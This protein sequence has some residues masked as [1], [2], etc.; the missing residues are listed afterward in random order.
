MDAT[1]DTR[2]KHQAL[3]NNGLYLGLAVMI[4]FF[5]GSGW[6]SYLNTRTLQENT[7][8]LTRSQD[9]LL[10][11]SE[12]LSLLKDAETGQRGY[13]I[14]GDSEY[15]EPYN[16]AVARIKEK[17]ADIEHLVE[18]NL[19]QKTMLPSLRERIDLKLQEL[20]ETIELRRAHGFEQAKEVIVT[21]RGKRTM[22][23]I[24]AREDEMQL[25]ERQLRQERVI[26]MEN[27]YRITFGSGIL[28]GLLGIVLSIAVTYLLRRAMLVRGRHEWLQTAQIRLAQVIAGDQKMV[29]LS[30]KILNFLTDSLSAQAGALYVEDGDFQR[31]AMVGVPNAAAIPVSFSSGDGLLGQAVKEQRTVMLQDVLPGQLPIGSALAKTTPCQVLIVPFLVDGQVYGVVELGFL[32]PLSGLDLE[33]VERISETLGVAVRSVKSRENQQRLLEETQ[34]QARALQEQSEELRVTNE[35]LEVQG[36]ALRESQVKLETQRTQLELAGQI[37]AEFLTKVSQELRTPLDSSLA[38]AKQ[39]AENPAGNLTVEQVQ[40]AR[41][42]HQ[43]GNALLASIDEILAP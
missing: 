27:A 41:T 22:D 4:L 14:T 39:L 12:L 37:K 19:K 3:V 33:L 40:L 2:Y 35:E 31:Q 6:F 24:R 16:T 30:Q 25:A 11:L 18:G 5:V 1:K 15:L 8:V 28:T 29:T 34:Q 26:E 9:V 17:L 7:T 20:A 38:L 10:N 43:T 13:V 32:H 42:I 23:D 36:R 21:N